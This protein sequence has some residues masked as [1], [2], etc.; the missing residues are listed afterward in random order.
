MIGGENVAIKLG[1][2]VTVSQAVT[3]GSEL[4]TPGTFAIDTNGYT[5]SL[6]GTLYNATELTITG[7]GKV[8]S[9]GGI[10]QGFSLIENR[11]TLIWS[12]A[13]IHVA[14]GLTGITNYSILTMNSGAITTD[15]GFDPIST[16]GVMYPAGVED[17]TVVADSIINVATETGW[18]NAYYKMEE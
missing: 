18:D 7:T 16:Y 14:D 2:P 15:T 17:T 11:G 13:T 5:L 6:N 9:G 8:Q 1:A 12:D 4:T 10:Q 3:L